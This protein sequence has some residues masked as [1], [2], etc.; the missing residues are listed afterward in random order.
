MIFA[1][2]RWPFLNP[3]VTPYVALCIVYLVWGTTLGSIHI[4]VKTFPPI[5]LASFR[6]IGA[7]VML[8]T[9]CKLIRHEQWP[10]KAS[11]KRNGLIGLLLFF[12]GHSVTYWALRYVSTGLAAVLSSTNVFWMMC[13]ASQVPPK[14]KIP[15]LAWASTFVGFLGLLVLLSPQLQ[16][17]A[18]FSLWFWLSIIGLLV[19]GFC[20]CSGSIMS[21]RTQSSSSLLMSLGVQQLVGGLLQLPIGLATMTSFH[22][23]PAAWVALLYLIVIASGL[24]MACYLYTL[25]TLPIPVLGTVAYVTPVLTILFGY[26]FLGEAITPAMMG[27]TVIILLSVVVVQQSTRKRIRSTDSS[28]PQVSKTR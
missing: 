27:G 12:L 18:A 9:F 24:A 20:W 23:A 10:D 6:F 11:L 25:D 3:T 15:P 28:L 19:T 7:G 14:E 16:H 22:P 4:A 8:I 13:L 21:R 2:R 17:H 5:L 1:S 26:F